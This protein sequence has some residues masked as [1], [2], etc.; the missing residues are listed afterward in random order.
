MKKGQ[1]PPNAGK[2]YPAQVLSGTDLEKLLTACDE[3]SRGEITRWR[4][5]ALIIVL[6]RVGLRISEAL[7]LTLPDVDMG[8]RE[9]K[10]RKAKTKAGIRTVGLDE[11]AHEALD[12]WLA[13]RPSVTQ[14][15]FVS[16]P[17]GG[18]G[19][20]GQ[21]LAYTTADETL[22][23]LAR[24][25]GV[26]QRVHLHGLRHQFATEMHREGVPLGVLQHALGHK[27]PEITMHYA[28]HVLDR[29]EVTQAMQ[30]RGAPPSNGNPGAGGAQLSPSLQAIAE[31]VAELSASL[32]LMAGDTAVRETVA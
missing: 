7:S 8:A 6:W 17:H 15:V 4:N 19:G 27:N 24:Q 2:R 11:M 3:H 29:M 30:R 9:L 28:A 31:Q 32:A 20:G 12:L 25:A 10:I 21:R 14:W 26:K 22:K 23:R 18:G 1:K 13:N 5:R 16:S